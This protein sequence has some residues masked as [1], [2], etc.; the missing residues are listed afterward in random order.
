MTPAL[1]AD[2]VVTPDE[3]VTLAVAVTVPSLGKILPVKPI[4]VGL[5]VRVVS[6]TGFSIIRLTFPILT[7]TDVALGSILV[8]VIFFSRPP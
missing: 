1:S 3:S 6:P 4:S 8:I 7:V 2:E 5:T